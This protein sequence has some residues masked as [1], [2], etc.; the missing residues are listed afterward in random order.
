MKFAIAV[1][2]KTSGLVNQLKRNLA[3]AAREE[4]VHRYFGIDQYV[5]PIDPAP[6]FCL[7]GC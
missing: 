3:C 6:G 2:E 1:G 4:D 5:R 7:N